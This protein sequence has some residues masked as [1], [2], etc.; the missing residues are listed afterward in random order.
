MSEKY[1]SVAITRVAVSQVAATADRDAIILQA[2]AAANCMK[3][4]T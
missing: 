3:L 4:F 1:K 2:H